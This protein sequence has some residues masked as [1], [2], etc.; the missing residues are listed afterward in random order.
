MRRFIPVLL[1]L[2]LLLILA[3]SPAAAAKPV[4]GCPGPFELMTVATFRERSLQVGVPP[5]FLASDWEESLNAQIDKNDDG[6]F[7]V[8]DLPDTPGTFDGW[9]FNVTDNTARR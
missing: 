4:G 7:C 5:E 8:Q 1:A 2:S 3:A 6:K 9:I